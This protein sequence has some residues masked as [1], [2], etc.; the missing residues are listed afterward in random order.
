MELNEFLISARR[1]ARAET[2]AW[3]NSKVFDEIFSERVFEQDGYVYMQ[4]YFGTYPCVGGE[5]VFYEDRPIWA[6]NYYGEMIDR[7]ISFKEVYDFL[8]NAFAQVFDQFTCRGPR[9]YAAGRF[10]YVNHMDGGL[11]RFKGKETVT[12]N[13]EKVFRLDYHGGLID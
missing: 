2:G 12:L 9:L 6:M 3:E 7:K 8:G 1:N 4:R 13:G 5:V 10:V 11:E